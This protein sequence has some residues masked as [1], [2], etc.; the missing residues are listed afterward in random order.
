[1]L[2]A[3]KRFFFGSPTT[4]N[5]VLAPLR[6]AQNDLSGVIISR[7]KDR[8]YKTN[9]IVELTNDIEADTVE[10]DLAIKV[11]ANLDGLLS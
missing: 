10:I 5:E 8:D 9:Q 2:E 4:V 3:I 7:G 1:M 6:R 11:K